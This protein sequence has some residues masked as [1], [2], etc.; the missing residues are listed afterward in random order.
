MEHAESLRILERYSLVI[1]PALVV[2]EQLGIP[3]PAVPALL[4]IGALAAAG[5]VS[6]PLVLG[7][8]AGVL[9]KLC[10][11]SLQPDTCVGRTEHVFAR[12]GAAFI[13]VAKFVPGLTTVVPPLAGMAAI[14]RARFALYELGG[15]LLW[16]GTWVGLG[17]FF[18]DAISSIA[19]SATRLGRMLGVVVLGAVAAYI[20]GR[21]LRRRLS[22]RTLRLVRSSPE[23]MKE[24][25]YAIPEKPPGTVAAPRVRAIGA[26]QIRIERGNPR[27]ERDQDR[28]DGT[29][30]DT[31]LTV[32][33][34]RAS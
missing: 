2:A 25:P 5:Q 6:L 13:L 11:M 12:Y 34:R 15:V 1:L 23:A 17:Y 9:S 31:L 27:D 10:R 18:S 21:Y 16:A 29:R 22:L 4:G 26:P 7:A 8:S 20:L 3:V 14:G 28:H 33:T 32:V 24:M 30:D 19:L